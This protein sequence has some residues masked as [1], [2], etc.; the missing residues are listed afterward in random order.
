[1]YVWHSSGKMPENKRKKKKKEK[2]LKFM[3][4]SELNWNV[5]NH[6]Y[7]NERIQIKLN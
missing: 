7:E 3:N 6:I 5:Y 2:N 1:M 4:N